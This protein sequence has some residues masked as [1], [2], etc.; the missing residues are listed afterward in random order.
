MKSAI[1]IDIGGTKVAFGLLDNKQN[2][3]YQLELKSDPTDRQRM[4]DV[5]VAGIKK[6]LEDNQLQ[7]K[8]VAFG[9]GVPGIINMAGGIAIFQNNLPW[10]NF[11]LI[12]ELKKTF[13]KVTHI[14][15]DN[16]VSCAAIAE[17]ET[18]KLT[19]NDSMVFL[20]IS[21]GV[22]SPVIIGGKSVK[23]EGTAGEIG[24]LSIWCPFTKR[25]ERLEEATSGTAIAKFGQQVY[26][27]PKVTTKEV[28]ERYGQQD[29]SATEIIESVIC[30]L[31][32]AIY[33]IGCLIDP[34][35]IVLGG[36]VIM[37]NPFLLERLKAELRKYVI[38]VQGHLVDALVMSKHDN[39]AG[40]IG[41]AISAIEMSL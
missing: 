11:P 23:G 13:P 32:Q 2:L 33:S 38:P 16:D 22:A 8:E 41:A 34:T 30:S 7:E 19:K 5:V 39:N 29:A 14:K 27:N 28:F 21:T 15:M 10:E 4:Y 24:L 26:Q 36:S 18:L 6:L 35:K 12:D 31:A 20:T 3:I 17:W 40:L 37:K 25:L 1:G 9:I